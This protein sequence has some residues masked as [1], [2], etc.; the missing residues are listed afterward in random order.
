MTAA[1][2]ISLT[3]HLER[4]ERDSICVRLPGAEVAAVFLPTSQIEIAPERLGRRI[5]V[6]LPRWLA[7]AKGLVSKPDPNQGVLL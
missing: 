4:E 3:L 7:E 6:T 5:L 2:P 1:P